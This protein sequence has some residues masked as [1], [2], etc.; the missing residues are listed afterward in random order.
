MTWQTP[1]N[2]RANDNDAAEGGDRVGGPPPMQTNSR[3]AV[4]AADYETERAHREME[5]AERGAPPPMATNSRFAAA[6]AE[7]GCLIQLCLHGPFREQQLVSS[8]EV[9]LA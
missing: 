9:M 4:A 3:F 6:A 1:S 5:R 8:R 2:A 7:G